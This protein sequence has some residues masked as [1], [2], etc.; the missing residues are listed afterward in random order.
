[1]MVSLRIKCFSLPCVPARRKDKF[2]KFLDSM[3][4]K[5]GKLRA[6]VKDL[7]TKYADDDGAKSTLPS[8]SA[9]K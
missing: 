9:I 1:M 6:L 3:M 4:S 5:T 8:L 2:K 7:K